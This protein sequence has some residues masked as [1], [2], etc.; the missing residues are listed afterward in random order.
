[1]DGAYRAWRPPPA[2]RNHAHMAEGKAFKIHFRRVDQSELLAVDHV[3]PR[4]VLLLDERSVDR[5]VA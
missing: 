2:L 4:I 5:D 3:D 1:M